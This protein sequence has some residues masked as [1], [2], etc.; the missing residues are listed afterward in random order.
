MHYSE[1]Q[2]SKWSIAMVCVCVWGIEELQDMG[3]AFSLFLILL[4]LLLLDQ[5]ALLLARI[6]SVHII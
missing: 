6:L 1:P 4:L 3:P 2:V 5:H